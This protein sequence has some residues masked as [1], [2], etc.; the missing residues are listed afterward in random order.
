MILFLFK[1]NFQTI[2][3]NDKHESITLH[4]S[5]TSNESNISAYSS[6]NTYVKLFYQQHWV[7]FMVM[8]LSTNVVESM[9]LATK[10][11]NR[12]GEKLIAFNIQHNTALRRE[13]ADV[14]EN[15]TFEAIQNHL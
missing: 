13:R 3:T 12:S 7:I 15:Y 10:D 1:C 5:N 14:T 4:N 2:V 8:M 11:F 6:I 9:I